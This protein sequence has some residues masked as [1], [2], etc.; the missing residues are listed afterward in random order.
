MTRKP[1]A[2]NRLPLL[3]SNQDSPDPESAVPGGLRAE[4]VG[5]STA[6]SSENRK[7]THGNPHGF[8]PP[9]PAKRSSIVMAEFKR[10]RKR[11][12]E[13]CSWTVPRGLALLE[14]HADL[15][16][17]HHVVPI[18]CGGADAVENLIL[19]CPTCHGIAHA[20]GRMEN[21]GDGGTHLW[22]GPKS[23]DHLLY[24]LTLLRDRNGWR[25]YVEHGRNYADVVEISK[26]QRAVQN[27]ERRFEVV[28]AEPSVPRCAV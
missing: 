18:A 5:V 12:C 17:G 1:R 8:S 10:T 27:G 4:S 21:L 9:A 19:L 23:R 24:E 28:R 13:A 3:G 11:K 6:K 16:H 14:G 2:L 20:L 25:A 15:L 7:S 26:Y 22:H